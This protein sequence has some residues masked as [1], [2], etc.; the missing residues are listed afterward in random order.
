MTA[1]RIFW[2]V[3]SWLVAGLLMAP[4]MAG[5][6]S[7]GALGMQQL[8]GN[9]AR[10]D[11]GTRIDIAPCGADYCAVNTWVKNPNG[12]EHVG[13][14]LILTLQPAADA[15][16]KFQAY[17]VRRKLHFSMTITLQAA[18]MHT[19]GCVLLGVVCKNASWTR[20]N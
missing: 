10:D 7:T 19:S 11:G 20:I 12:K 9:W 4:L 16:L 8:S 13:D 17:D 6:A 15:V 5:A 3:A 18:S 1:P 2:L 14:R